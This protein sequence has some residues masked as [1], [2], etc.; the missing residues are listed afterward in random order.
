VLETMYF[1]PNRAISGCDLL[2]QGRDLSSQALL[3][4]TGILYANM[5]GRRRAPRSN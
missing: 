4:K 5:Q 2:S 3:E 1:P